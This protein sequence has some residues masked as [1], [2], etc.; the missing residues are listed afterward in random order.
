MLKRL[1]GNCKIKR[2]VGQLPVVT[3]VSLTLLVWALSV[4][5]V[6]A[7]LSCAAIDHA[8]FDRWVCDWEVPQTFW[9]CISGQVDLCPFSFYPTTLF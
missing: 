8:G 7:C 1:L 6:P 4:S 9:D 3:G 2:V 5:E